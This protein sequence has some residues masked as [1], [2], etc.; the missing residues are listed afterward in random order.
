ML[1]ED[2]AMW[3][4]R[5]G[6]QDP[7]FDWTVIPLNKDALGIVPDAESGHSAAATGGTDV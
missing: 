4:V 7:D 6:A 5:R 3:L 1:A 2:G